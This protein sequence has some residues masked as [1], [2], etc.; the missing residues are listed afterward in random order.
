MQRIAQELA[1][2]LVSRLDA[3]METWSIDR[4]AAEVKMREIVAPAEAIFL[5]AKFE[6]ELVELGDDAEAREMLADMGVEEPGLDVLADLRIVESSPESTLVVSLHALDSIRPH[7][8]AVEFA[9]DC[10]AVY[11]LLHREGRLV[12]P[13]AA[14]WGAFDPSKFVLLNG[15]LL[16]EA[17]SV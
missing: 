3:I 13:K 10:I 16:S 6:S 7:D 15:V 12:G 17:R 4:D 2:G 11:D 8:I 14:E 1:A 5:D 9:Q